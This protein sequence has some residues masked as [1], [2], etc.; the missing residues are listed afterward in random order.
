MIETSPLRNARSR[1]AAR[2]CA[3]LAAAASLAAPRPSVIGPKGAL[4]SPVIVVNESPSAP[5]GLYVR[6][7]AP[8]RRGIFATIP[9]QRVAGAYLRARGARDIGVRLL[10]RIAALHGDVVCASGSVVTR[11]HHI[12]A[13]RAARDHAGRTLPSWSGCRRL[14]ADQVFLM[15]DTP[16][17][18]DSRYWGPASTAAIDGIWRPLWIS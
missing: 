14:G 3:L 11:N 17:S 16:D 18:F 5:R 15:G 2:L 13:T 9:A 10:K 8:L 6:V 7:D 12:F 4:V 1:R